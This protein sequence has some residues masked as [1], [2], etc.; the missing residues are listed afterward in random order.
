[1]S[2]V[3]R[4]FLS[5]SGLDTVL[6]MLT[7]YLLFA[8]SGAAFSLDRR[9]A[10]TPPPEKSWAANVSLRLIQVHLCVIYLCAGLSKLQGAR[11][12]DGTAVWL[13][14]MPEE[15][16]LFDMSWLAHGGDVPCLLFSNV[17]VALT[18]A[19]EIGFAF[20]IWNRSLRPV[21]LGL[22]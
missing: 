3:H 1:L 14:V 4:A 12:W 15:F 11:W 21:F 8:P 18:L 17:G 6:A 9:R 7:F 13:T 2:F 22:V 16:A 5:W 19:T 10:R 20:L